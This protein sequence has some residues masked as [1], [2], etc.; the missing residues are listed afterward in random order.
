MCNVMQC[1]NIGCMGASQYCNIYIGKIKIE[2]IKIAKCK[3]NKKIMHQ[4]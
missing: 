3:F 4:F 1:V 2:K